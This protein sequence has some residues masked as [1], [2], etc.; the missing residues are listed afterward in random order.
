M[1]TAQEAIALV[2]PT[3]MNSERDRAVDAL[4]DF[5][6]KYDSVVQEVLASEEIGGLVRLYI[7]RVADGEMSPESSIVSALANGLIIG[8]EMEK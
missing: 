4:H 3:V 6:A 7:Q 5:V 2:I 1:K 8:M